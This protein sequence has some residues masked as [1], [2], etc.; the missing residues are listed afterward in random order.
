MKVRRK[1]GLVKGYESVNDSKIRQLDPTWY[2]IRVQ[3]LDTRISGLED[4]KPH[5]TAKLSEFKRQKG[6][7]SPPEVC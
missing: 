1:L 3:I 2:L 5:H 7:E 4:T 6:K